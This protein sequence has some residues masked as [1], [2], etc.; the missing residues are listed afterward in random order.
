[1]DNQLTII[2]LLLLKHFIVD[3]PLQKPYHYQNKGTYLHPGGLLHALLHGVGT[4]LIVGFMLNVYVGLWMGVLDAAVHYHVDWAKVKLN[5]RYQLT[6]TSSEKFW[7][8]LGIDQLIH[9]LTY[10]IIVVMIFK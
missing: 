3:F 5:N 1:M 10:V 9:Q 2:T 7:W 8:L 6:P 4:G